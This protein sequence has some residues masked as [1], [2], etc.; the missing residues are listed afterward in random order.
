MV[1]K[2]TQEGDRQAMQDAPSEV[3]LSKDRST[4]TLVFGTSEHAL[5]A[6]Y[7][8]VLTRS[9]EAR[10]HSPAQAKT[11]YGK[12]NVR[13]TGVEPIGNYALKLVFDDGHDSGIYAWSYLRELIDDR[14]T[15]WQA[16][17]DELKAKSLGRDPLF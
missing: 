2:P 6:E 11:V 5:D 14:E 12:R 4:L 8:R 15:L 13:I 17:L 16:Y 7:L 9:A 1:I 3:R 10:G